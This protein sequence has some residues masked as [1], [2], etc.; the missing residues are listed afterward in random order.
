[1]NVEKLRS[2]IEKEEQIAD[3]KIDEILE[4]TRRLKENIKIFKNLDHEYRKIEFR[5]D[6]TAEKKKEQILK[7]GFA[8]ET[9]IEEL[10]SDIK[11]G[12]RYIRNLT[13]RTHK[14]IERVRNE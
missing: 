4:K 1:M 12:M 8:V 10:A 6:K 2:R 9:K 5:W 13:E 11:K 3:I 14:K 7:K